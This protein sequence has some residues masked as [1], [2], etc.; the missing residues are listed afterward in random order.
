MDISRT[1]DV[2][3]RFAALHKAEDI[4]MADAGMIPV[5]FYNDYYLRRAT[6]SPAAGTLLYGYCDFQY[7]DIT[8]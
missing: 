7:A 2:E 1:T 4:I 8:E 6:R 5:A 3:E